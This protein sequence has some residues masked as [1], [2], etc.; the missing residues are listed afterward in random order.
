MNPSPTSSRFC[1]KS[2]VLLEITVEYEAHGC[3]RKNVVVRPRILSRMHGGTCWTNDCRNNYRGHTFLLPMKP[4]RIQKKGTLGFWIVLA[5]MLLWC[6]LFL[7]IITPWT[8]SAN[9]KISQIPAE[10]VI[11][12]PHSKYA[13]VLLV[14][15][16]LR[17]VP[18]IAL[19]YRSYWK[20][21]RRS[22]KTRWVRV[23]P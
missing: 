14:A 10:N 2:L 15:V 23:C 21:L 7:S 12:R 16:R 17:H 4:I 6:A 8:K 19:H 1:R 22:L 20:S 13:K 5:L 11:P 18:L 9:T 3:N